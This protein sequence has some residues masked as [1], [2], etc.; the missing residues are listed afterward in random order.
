M[1]D[2]KDHFASINAREDGSWESQAV[3]DIDTG[4]WPDSAIVFGKAGS[5]G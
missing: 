4:P 1:V 3:I 5:I 2:K